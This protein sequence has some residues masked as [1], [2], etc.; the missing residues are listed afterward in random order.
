MN[1]RVMAPWQ[2]SLFN[3]AALRQD[4]PFA[5]LKPSSYGLIM[6]DPPWHF[7][8]RSEAGAAKSPQAQYRTMSLDAIKAL[9]VAELAAADCLL[10]LWCTAA[11]L[12]EQAGVC[13]AWGFRISTTGVWVKRASASGRLAFGTGY[14]L[15]NCHES[16]V[17]GIKGAPRLARDV[18]S[19]VEAPRG[20]HSEKP[21]AAFAAAARLVPDEVRRIELFSRRDRPGWDAW[22]DEAGTMGAGSERAAPAIERPPERPHDD[23]TRL[24]N[25]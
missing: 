9:P 20:R 8:T 15:R 19:V 6:A 10:W 13:T 23:Q 21:A 16:F 4:W 17:I 7:R 24:A 5:D 3:G 18:R 1:R 2:P 11:G 22:G 12:L 14:V 25:D